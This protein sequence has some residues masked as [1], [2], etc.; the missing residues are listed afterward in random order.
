M[1]RK[2]KTKCGPWVVS[3]SPRAKPKVICRGA[4]MLIMF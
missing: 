4:L 3:L 1:C 2:G